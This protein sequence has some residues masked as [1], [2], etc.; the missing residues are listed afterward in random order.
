MESLADLLGELLYD[1]CFASACLAHEEKCLI[2]R[3]SL[4]NLLKRTYGGACV[5][6][7]ARLLLLR[8]E[9]F[10]IRVGNSSRESCTAKEALLV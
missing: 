4:A 9:I 6:E 3:H 7:F 5:H 1:C 10:I 8:V 2:E